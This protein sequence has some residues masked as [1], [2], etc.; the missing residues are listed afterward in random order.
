[1]GHGIGVIIHVS[2]WFD[3]PGKEKEMSSTTLYRLSGISLL[4]FAVISV[5]AGLMT[6]LFDS[7]LSASPSTIQNP[8]WSPYWSLV[9]VTLVLVLFGL[10]AFYLRQARGHG[11]VLG[12]IGVFLVVLGSALG[13]AMVAYFVSILPLLAEKAPN[14][15]NA[16]FYETSFGVFG[17]FS[18]VLGIIGP[19][20]LGIAVIRAKV[21]PPLVGVLLIVSGILSPST[22]LRGLLFTLLGLVGTIA[23]AIAYGG[24]GIILTKQPRARGAEVS[25]PAQAALR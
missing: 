3:I 14:L 2:A 12:L 5:I 8:L 7:S 18:A 16:G 11:S 23:A 10:P 17:L 19:F 9:F 25:S 15:I 22:E 21:F 4:L 1:M 13:M 20:V 24:V 6:L